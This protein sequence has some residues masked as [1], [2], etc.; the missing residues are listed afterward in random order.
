MYEILLKLLGVSG[1]SSLIQIFDVTMK[2]KGMIICYI[3]RAIAAGLSMKL[4]VTF[5]T[6]TL[7]TYQDS[8]KIVSDGNYTIDIALFAYPP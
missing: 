5:E 3:H 4:V 6:A 7:E 2:C 1:Y 8:L